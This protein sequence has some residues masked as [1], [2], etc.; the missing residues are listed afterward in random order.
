MNHGGKGAAARARGGK[1]KRA[2]HRQAI[3][4][5]RA[6]G[7]GVTRPDHTVGGQKC[8]N[9]VRGVAQP[10]VLEGECDSD[11]LVGI[12]SPI[13]GQAPFC[14]HHGAVHD[15][16][17]LNQR[18]NGIAQVDARPSDGNLGIGDEVPRTGQP[19][20]HL[21]GSKVGARQRLGGLLQ[22]R[23]RSSRVG[24]RRRGSPEAVVVIA[25]A[26]TA[27]SRNIGGVAIIA[28]GKE[29]Q[30]RGHI[31]VGGHPVGLAVV[32]RVIARRAPAVGGLRN[33]GGDVNA[34]EN[35]PKA[36]VIDSAHGNDA[37]NTGRPGDRV[38]VAVVPGR[39]EDRD[40]GSNGVVRR[41]RHRSNVAVA[42]AV[43]PAAA[44]AGADDHDRIGGI[45]IPVGD[46]P[47]PGRHHGI[48]QGRTGCA[49]RDFAGIQLRPR[50]D[51]PDI[52]PHGAEVA[53]GNACAAGSVG[54]RVGNRVC[55][56]VAKV[57]SAD[58]LAVGKPAAAQPGMVVV[59]AG[60]ADGDGDAG[61]IVGR[62]RRE[63]IHQ[64]NPLRQVRLQFMHRLD[65]FHPRIGEQLLE[66]GQG[67]ITGEPGLVVE[68]EP[69]FVLV[70]GQ[71]IQ[72]IVGYAPVRRVQR[73]QGPGFVPVRRQHG[74]RRRDK[75]DHYRHPVLPVGKAGEH[76]FWEEQNCPPNHCRGHGRW[77]DIAGRGTT[78]LPRQPVIHDLYRIGGTGPQGHRSAKHRQ[79]KEVP[80]Q[81]TVCIPHKGN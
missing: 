31:G 45:I 56:V 75:V 17:G 37:G 5:Q 38:A 26:V 61:P 34:G 15:D 76:L 53:R 13:P 55:V 65:G 36:G 41:S 28:G 9:Q 42:G 7:L 6:V 80:Q 77:R 43:I 79:Q 57:V 62:A 18:G 66:R 12:N 30:E 68:A 40:A 33:A 20:E 46:A 25:R 58:H 67:H 19:R 73:L 51:A 2:G 3:G 16:P 4:E 39:G 48:I 32:R 78:L 64:R 81:R 1:S 72:N 50:G 70:R 22:A 71:R 24:A 8:R 74:L 14:S 59:N 23:H 47:I 60:I 27:R 54:L 52:I 10:R 35:G 21:R 63:R 11:R 44:E 49:V 29:A 69:V